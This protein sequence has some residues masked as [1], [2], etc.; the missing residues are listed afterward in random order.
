[1]SRATAIPALLTA[2]F[3][4]G[5]G[6]V[7]VEEPPNEPLRA[8]VPPVVE[9]DPSVGSEVS[10]PIPTLAR[11][12]AERKARRGTL[13]V[14]NTACD[15]VSTGSGFA[16]DAHTLITNRHVLAGASL[17]EVSTWSGR[18]L[19]VDSASVSRLGDLGIAR[20]ERRLPE[21]LPLGRQVASGASV[22]AVGYPLGGELRLLPGVVVDYVSGGKFGIPGH[23][24]RLTA[25]VQP[26]NSGGPVLD[27]RG[28]VVAVV[29]AIELATDL[30]LA[31]PVETLRGLVAGRDLESLPPCGSE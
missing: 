17:L 6:G 15:G 8:P 20:V 30:A 22:T 19:D 31:I 25:N 29:F 13:R 5:C 14:R 7:V 23:V 10:A 26:G 21:V 11:D 24:M 16:L 4:A 28:R 27:A 18:T 12:S 3:L 1:M 9:V 2:A